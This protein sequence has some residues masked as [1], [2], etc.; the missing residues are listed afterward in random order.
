MELTVHNTTNGANAAQWS[1][2]LAVQTEP[3]EDPETLPR[4]NHTKVQTS[5]NF[6]VEI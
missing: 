5:V 1:S 2:Q 3:A 6:L 4:S